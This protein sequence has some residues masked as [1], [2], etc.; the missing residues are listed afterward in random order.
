MEEYNFEQLE[1]DL[2]KAFRQE[3]ENTL[4]RQKEWN[5]SDTERPISKAELL[6]HQNE[7]AIRG[8]YPMTKKRLLDLIEELPDGLVIMDFYDITYPVKTMER[9][10]TE[11]YGD[12]MTPDDLYMKYL[13]LIKRV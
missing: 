6:F 8:N 7:D 9:M 4:R 12:E 10:L 13:R 2:D 1:N 11:F 3:R 5:E